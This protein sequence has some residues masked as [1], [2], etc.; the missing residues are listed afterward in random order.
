MAIVY[1]NVTRD[2]KDLDLNMN[3]HPVRKDVNKHVGDL[4]VINSI[5]NILSTNKNE[6]LFN[7]SFGGNIRALLFEN[8]DNLTAI[9]MEKQIVN[10]VENFEPRASISKVVVTPEPDINSFKVYLE[11]FIVN[12]T[13]P[14][15]IT[16]QLER[17]R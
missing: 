12:R 13:D 16:F 3:I 9:R 4:A 15:A 5:K 1:T 14:I 10:M 17:T 7:P 2:F 11:F 6:R 8:A